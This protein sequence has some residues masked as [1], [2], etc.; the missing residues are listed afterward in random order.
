MELKT[1]SNY[2]LNRLF[3]LVRQI[4]FL[5]VESVG[6]SL[7]GNMREREKH[8][9][10]ITAVVSVVLQMQETSLWLRRRRGNRRFCA[11]RLHAPESPSPVPAVTT[12]LFLPLHPKH[13]GMG[14]CT[15]N[16]KKPSFS[17][18]SCRL[19]QLQSD[20]RP[21][22]QAELTGGKST[23]FTPAAAQAGSHSE[24]IICFLTLVFCLPVPGPVA[25][26]SRLRITS[27]PP[28]QRGN[29]PRS[30][31]PNGRCARSGLS[32]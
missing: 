21:E 7:G 28:G 19:S 32:W 1:L 16:C 3:Y 8:E 20:L 13:E 14:T 23:D 18:F 26:R 4:V 11:A 31:V 30:A 22:R 27:P 29:S 10:R 24:F 12:F 2:I 9:G 15:E 6:L 17:L 25:R 5:L